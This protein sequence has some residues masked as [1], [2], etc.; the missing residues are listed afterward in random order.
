MYVCVVDIKCF[1]SILFFLFFFLNFFYF[2]LNYAIV[3]FDIIIL[4]VFNFGTFYTCGDLLLALFLLFNSI[5][6]VFFLFICILLLNFIF[7]VCVLLLSI[8]AFIIYI[9]IYIYISSKLVTIYFPSVYNVCAISE[10]L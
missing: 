8:S 9:Y 6:E 1:P 5:Y 3:T 7:L 2:F 4:I 10:K